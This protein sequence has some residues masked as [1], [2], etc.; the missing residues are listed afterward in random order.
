MKRILIFML[1]LLSVLGLYAKANKQTVVLKCD[2]HCEGCCNKIMKNIAFE[3]GV[4]DILCDLPTKTVTV[5]YDAN[6]TDVQKLLTAFEQIGKPATVQ[7][8][9]QQD[10]QPVDATT[11]ATTSATRQSE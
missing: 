11:D 3:R 1:A 10:P 6:K 2:I 5:T 8:S 7:S 9:S 4:T